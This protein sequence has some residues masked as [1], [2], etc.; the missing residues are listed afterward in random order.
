[1]IVESHFTDWK[2][3]SHKC[4]SLKFIIQ[5]GLDIIKPED[6]KKWLNQTKEFEKE[7]TKRKKEIFGLLKEHVLNKEK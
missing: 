6:V 7:Y 1:M 4:D 3:I 5:N 2:Y